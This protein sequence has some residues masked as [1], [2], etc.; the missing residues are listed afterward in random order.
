[1]AITLIGDSSN[2][3]N[4]ASSM[5]LSV[6][7][8]TLDDDIIVFFGSCD[9]AG[10]LLPSGF[11]ELENAATGGTH[12]NILAYRI[13]S[14]EPASYTI[15]T[16]GAL[17]ERGIG[18]FATYRGQDTVAP[19]NKSNVNNGGADSTAVMLA[20]TPDQDNSLVAVFVGTERGNS[21]NPFITS[22][23]AGL[24]LQLDNV[25]GPGGNFNTSSCGAYADVLQTTAQEVSGN[26]ALNLS[27]TT[28]WGVM[29]VVL[30]PLIVG[31]AGSS[32]GSATVAGVGDSLTG[33]PGTAAGAAIVLGV[34]EVG[35]AGEGLAAGQATV[36]GVL[37]ANSGG[38]GSVT[39][40]SSVLGFGVAAIPGDGAAA[41][42]AIVSGIGQAL[43]G[44][45]G[46]SLGIAVVNGVGDFAMPTGFA[47]GEAIV[48]G[49]GSFVGGGK[50]DG[51]RAGQGRVGPKLGRGRIVGSPTD[52]GF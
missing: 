22:S 38:E 30:A 21:G 9:G 43:K 34:G 45:I 39:G 36:T 2:N 18:I 29:S 27:G 1:M 46:L 8:G 28:F 26:F 37:S 15:N 24:T 51:L 17:N 11:I 16:V 50:S 40:T 3:V 33:A 35:I 42:I 32:T 10:F 5:S 19:V 52:S 20:L 49:V 31:G 13:A 7:V 44:G 12:A 23:P 47:A 4:N 25:N 14:S 41:G 48:D 6:P